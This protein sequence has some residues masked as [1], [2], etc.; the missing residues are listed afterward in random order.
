MRQL[1][2]LDDGKKEDLSWMFNQFDAAE[3]WCATSVDL[4]TF[5]ADPAHNVHAKGG[6]VFT[7]GGSIEAYNEKIEHLNAAVIQLQQATE[8]FHKS[9]D[10]VRKK[11]G[12]TAADAELKN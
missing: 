12:V 2:Q 10:A 1:Q 4:Y 6:Q 11:H 5:A 7:E 8:A 3:K 9:Q